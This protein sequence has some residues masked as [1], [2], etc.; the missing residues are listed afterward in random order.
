M[1]YQKHLLSLV[2]QNYTNAMRDLLHAAWACDDSGDSE[3]AVLCRRKSLLLYDKL[4]YAMEICD[5]V[6]RLLVRADMLRRSRQFSELIKEIPCIF[7]ELWQSIP[8][9]QKYICNRYVSLEPEK[10]YAIFRFQKMLAE[11]GDDGCHSVRELF[12]A[13]NQDAT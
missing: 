5:R 8:I 7:A 11:R 9:T 2:A 4:P 3:N 6:N 10:V 12:P 13:Q 1:L